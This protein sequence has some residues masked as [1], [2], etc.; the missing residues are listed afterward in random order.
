MLAELAYCFIIILNIYPPYCFEHKEIW[1]IFFTCTYNSTN[2]LVLKP[3][4]SVGRWHR[5]NTKLAFAFLGRCPLLTGE[6]VYLEE[7]LRKQTITHDHITIFT[8]LC[9]LA[10]QM[11]FG[12]YLFT[13][14]AG[15]MDP[16]T[17][18]PGFSLDY[19]QVHCGRKK[20]ICII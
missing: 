4:Y 17:V 3:A 7:L 20:N 19:T 13:L 18:S 16:A 8:Y 6:T 1:H 10:V 12:L 5:M 14:P 11:P 2:M 9:V 15:T